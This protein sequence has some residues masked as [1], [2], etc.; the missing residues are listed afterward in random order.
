MQVQPKTW[1]FNGKG[2]T[3]LGSKGLGVIADEI[4]SVLPNTVDTYKSKLDITDANEIDIKRFDA[5]EITW[6][7]VN[8]VKELK[9]EL[10][11]AKA[12]I[13]ALKG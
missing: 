7:L 6:L 10:D 2:G 11:A 9:T 5:T 12:E 3:K 13:A 8:S 1:E 4:Q